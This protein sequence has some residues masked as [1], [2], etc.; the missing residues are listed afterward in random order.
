MNKIGEYNQSTS[1]YELYTH[2]SEKIVSGEIKTFSEIFSYAK[3][4]NFEKLN[5]G[6]SILKGLFALIRKINWG[7]FN[8]L[9]KDAYPKLW[10]IF[11]TENTRYNFAGDLKL[12]LSIADIYIAMLDIHGYTK[13]CEENKNNL[14]KM[15]ALDDLMQNKVS[16][17]TKFY[18]VISHRKQGDEIIMVCPSATDALS[19]T[20][21]II[22][23][24]SKKRLLNEYPSVDTSGLPDF[25]I[26]AGISGGNT[27]TSLIIT[28]DGDLS[29]FL[30]NNAARMQAR[31]NTLA[32][33]E[34]KVIVTKNLQYNFLKENSKSKSEIFEKNII[35]FYDNG[36]ISF[37]GTE[38][39]IVEAIFN[40]EEKYKEQFFNEMEELVKSVKGNLWKQRMFTSILDLIS[41]VTSSMP[42]F[43]IDEQVN[44]Y[45]SSCTNTTICDLCDKA[46]GA[47]VVK[48]NYKEAIDT[49]SLIVNLLK[50][51][52]NFDKMVLEYAESI[53]AGYEKVLPIYDVVIKKDIE[54]N[55][56]E[57]FP[58]NHIPIFQNVQKANETY[59]KLMNFAMSSKTLKRRK[60]IWYGILEKEL[61]N[62]V[63]NMYSGKK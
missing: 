35:S 15:H 38:I 27:N 22:G 49:F 6:K 61:P 62:L 18:N 26:S 2:L 19:A 7:F 44:E 43:Q 13:F 28:E 48:E 30:I 58:A 23:V 9:D 5:D 59:N 41:K 57:I 42:P 17:V 29:G 12:S 20:I 60:S 37:K 53:C 4:V 52:P 24:L 47:Y 56:Y 25:K 39:P 21:A 1:I 51:I 8:N 34:N 14:S 10:S 40:E 63:I 55:I 33:K 54:A 16:E 32:P 50:T 31:A 46:N 36:M 11:V 3:N 45:I